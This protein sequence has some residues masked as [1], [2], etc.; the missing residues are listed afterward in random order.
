[1]RPMKNKAQ[2]KPIKAWP[3][4]Y[5]YFPI[6]LLTIVGI[7]DSI[8]LAVSHYRVHADL[9]Y[10]SFCALSRAFNCDTV[11]SSPYAVFL[12]VPL[13]IWGIVGYFLV[14]CLLILA[15]RQ[16]LERK[17]LWPLLFWIS[18]LYSIGSL[19][20]AW[21]SSKLIHSYCIMCIFSYFVNFLLLYYAWFVNRRFGDVGLVRGLFQD[22]R[23]LWNFRKSTVPSMVLIVFISVGLITGLPPYWRMTPPA[24][25]DSV[26][27][28][29]TE[30]GYPYIGAENPTL[31]ITEFSDY[32]C[33]Q[34][35][36]MHFFLR[37]LVQLHPDQIRLVHRHFPMDKAYN[38]LLSDTFHTGSGKMAII[39]L[40]AQ[41]K[42]KFWEAN[43]FLYGLAEQKADFNTRTI[44]EALGINGNE[45]NVALGNRSL[46]LRLKHDI[47]SG[48]RNGIDGTPSF[49]IDGKV[50]LG[51]IPSEILNFYFK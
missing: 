29:V 4:R 1:M 45:L 25:S 48:I 39:A 26:F 5:Y 10:S 17:R 15:G 16:K 9:Y 30:D 24:L 44:A 34:C 36:K 27:R 8:Y 42:N 21:I 19:I 43:D 7:V 31:T 50:Y 18:L 41:E 13:G 40:Y 14:L 28:G 46:R 37:K 12:N 33:F 11:S 23:A 6:I 2:R 49:I 32:M 38:P 3:F 22:L 35:K 47:A 51:K 20:L